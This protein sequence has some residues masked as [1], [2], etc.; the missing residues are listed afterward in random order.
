MAC[1]KF[2]HFFSSLTTSTTKNNALKR[3]LCVP[4]FYYS[5]IE[6]RTNTFGMWYRVVFCGMIAWLSIHLEN[7]I[8]WLI[9][10]FAQF[11]CRRNS[12]THPTKSH[13]FF[14]FASMRSSVLKDF[15]LCSFKLSLKWMGF[16]LQ[17]GS[18]IESTPWLHIIKYFFFLMWVLL[19]FFKNTLQCRGVKLFCL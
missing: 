19:L 10:F 14:V 5:A 11:T 8:L 15:F 13:P 18:F 9:A 6:S 3:V 1:S 2:Q 7:I 4:Y 12:C 17:C 16:V